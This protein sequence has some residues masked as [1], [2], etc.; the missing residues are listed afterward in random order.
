MEPSSAGK[1]HVYISCI[2]NTH[3]CVHA[4]RQGETDKNE[5]W[6][7][8]HLSCINVILK[9]TQIETETERQRTHLSSLPENDSCLFNSFK[10]GFL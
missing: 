3:I 6:G 8:D 2:L 7:K 1:I 4:G 10:A 5:H 9:H